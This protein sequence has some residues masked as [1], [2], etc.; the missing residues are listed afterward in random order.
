MVRAP[1]HQKEHG[2]G[3]S[4]AFSVTRTAAPANVLRRSY[5]PPLR[6]LAFEEAYGYCDKPSVGGHG[7]YKA[8]F[9]VGKNVLPQKKVSHS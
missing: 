1:L 7:L 3:H 5:S 9:V 8:S 6:K 4:F 2:Y